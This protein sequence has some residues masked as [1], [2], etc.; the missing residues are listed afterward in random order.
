LTVVIDAEGVVRSAR[1]GGG[2]SAEQE[3]AALRSAIDSVLN[4]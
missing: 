1:V 2:A 4:K 3:A